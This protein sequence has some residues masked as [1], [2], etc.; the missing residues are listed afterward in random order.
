M[1][2]Q[3][4]FSTAKKLILS[5]D[6]K[7]LSDLL[8]IVKKTPLA[9]AMKTGPIRLNTLI[10]NPTLFTFDDAYKIAEILGVE[11]GRIVMIIHNE[12]ISRKE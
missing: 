10:S 6:I 1:V 11:K 9:K 7:N 5:G 8:A 2:D 3:P 12:N 4:P